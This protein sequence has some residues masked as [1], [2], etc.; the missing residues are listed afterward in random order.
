[1]PGLAVEVDNY[2]MLFSELNGTDREGKKSA[3]PQA[4][5]NQKSENG[6]VP[7]ASET[8]ALGLQQQRTALLSSE[9][10]T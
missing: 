6:M 9:P 3:A 10:V 7:L 2:P 5:T 1:M 4:T 8:I